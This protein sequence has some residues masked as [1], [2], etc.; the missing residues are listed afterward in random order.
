MHKYFILLSLFIV[1]AMPFDSYTAGD[2]DYV[3]KIRRIYKEKAETGDIKAMY[4][5]GGT[6]CCSPDTPEPSYV[7]AYFWW[8]LAFKKGSPPGTDQKQATALYIKLKD[9]AEQHL[10][11]EQKSDVQRRVADWKPSVKKL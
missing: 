1:A 9:Y 4:E 10:T 2:L 8:S 6:Y 7:E 5:L 11:D 3:H